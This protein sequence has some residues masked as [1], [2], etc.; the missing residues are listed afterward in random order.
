MSKILEV[1]NLSKHFS[2]L[3]AVD[4]ISFTLNDG[5]MAALIGP[6][7]AGKTTCFNML[8][9]ALPASTG[10]ILFNGTNITAWPSHRRAKAGIG[11]TFQ[12]A[13]TFRSMTVL[14]NVE[15]ALMTARRDRAA[16][17]PLLGEIG[18]A[19]KAGQLVTELAYGDVKRVELAMVL[20]TEPQLLLL[21][22]PTAGMASGERRLIMQTIS[23]LV[24]A[25]GIT[26]L[27]TEHDMDAV[28]GFASRILVLS[29]GRMIADGAPDAIRADALVQDVYFGNRGEDDA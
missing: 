16:A 1:Q 5:D 29:Q 23:A 14:E 7:G 19:D 9:G 24:A 4:Q 3:V 13:Q 22:E 6:N 21:D 27:F 10:R 15:T 17:L 25:R 2:G 26:V 11:R 8:G 12:I 18:I 20:A 28:F